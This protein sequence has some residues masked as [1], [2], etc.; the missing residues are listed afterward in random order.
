MEPTYP[1]DGGGGHAPQPPGNGDAAELLQRI[2][3]PG[4]PTPS[5]LENPKLLEAALEDGRYGYNEME[6]DTAQEGLGKLEAMRQSTLRAKASTAKPL[7]RIGGKGAIKTSTNDVSLRIQALAGNV[8][9][10]N[11]EEQASQGAIGL[12]CAQLTEAFES[13]KGEQAMKEEA[14]LQR[15]NMLEQRIGDYEQK[16]AAQ[17]K[18]IK[19]LRTAGNAPKQ[20]LTARHSAPIPAQASAST[21]PPAATTLPFTPRLEPTSNTATDRE[22]LP[23]PPRNPRPETQKQP[24]KQ[25]QSYAAA[26]S[27]GAK[28]QE[29]QTISMRP[30]KSTPI[31]RNQDVP[32]PDKLKPIR[33][34]NKEARRLIFRREGGIRSPEVGK[35]EIIL[36]INR[37]LARKGFPDFAR[38]VDANYTRTGAISVLLE[39]GTLGTMLIPHYKDLLVSA[40]RQVDQATIS[41]ELPEQWYKVKVHGVATRRYLQLGL[42]L[43]REEIE[44][45]TEY[46]L[47][48]DPVW[49]RNPQD[50]NGKGSTIVITVG[51]YET[52]K[53][54]LVNGIRF[55]GTRHRA[56][57]FWELGE[58]TIC[59]RCCGTGHQGFRACGDRPVCCFIC[60]GDHEGIEHICK[61]VNC[62]TKGA[63]CQHTPAKCGNCKGPHAA[64]NCPK[65]RDVRTKFGR[66]ET[67]ESRNLIPETESFDRQTVEQVANGLIKVAK[68]SLTDSRHAPNQEDTDMEDESRSKDQTT[69]AVP[70]C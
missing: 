52:Y 29:W 5:T 59:P 7:K 25:T 31:Q 63:A 65:I 12:L 23:R 19:E 56:E 68:G 35:E 66:Q 54:I 48:R 34:K 24:E 58:D 38:A 17:E 2:N 69:G 28:N 15:F 26:A 37:T 10:I 45:G 14:Y 49:I 64:L 4:T 22:Y 13:L 1:Q 43:A 46:K 51:S 40:V 30:K 3:M 42:G 16:L 36:V 27:A 53:K 18:E 39:R 47:M 60:A 6:Q 61:V 32:E 11:K 50:I 41:V 8:E 70:K 33:E 57:R 55:G 21:I 67:E 44:L 62:S 9:R 20:I